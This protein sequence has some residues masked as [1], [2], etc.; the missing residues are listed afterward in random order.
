MNDNSNHSRWTQ[1]GKHSM[2][3]SI[4]GCTV[5]R[6]VYKRALHL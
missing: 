4:S 1:I 5:S 6:I 3:V 2:S